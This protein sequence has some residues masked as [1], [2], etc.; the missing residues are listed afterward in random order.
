MLSPQA[1]GKP[2]LAGACW[3][4]TWLIVP[5]SAAAAKSLQSCPT[6]CDP[7]DVWQPTRPRSPWGSLGKNTGVG[8]HF[9]LPCM[10]VKSA[11]GG[12]PRVSGDS[13]RTRGAPGILRPPLLPAPSPAA[14]PSPPSPPCSS[15]LRLPP[16]PPAAPRVLERCITMTIHYTTDFI[17]VS[18][19]FPPSSLFRAHCPTV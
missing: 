14:R 10:K 7:I 11:L 6:L 3:A 19:V 16:A 2:S 17:G 5:H 12:G 4:Q 8:C 1:P 15:A 18:S 9:L 13:E